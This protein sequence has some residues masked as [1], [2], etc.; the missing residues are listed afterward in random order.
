MTK[1]RI[2]LSED[3]ITNQQ[4]CLAILK[5]LGYS[6][7]VV[8]NGMEA[9]KAL[10]SVS[11]DLVLMDCQMPEMNGYETSRLV[12]DPATDIPNH[13]IPII[14]L[15]A[16][17]SDGGRE[18]CLEAG[19]ND[20]I[21]KPLNP[22]EL[23]EA[24]TRWLPTENEA[25]GSRGSDVPKRATACGERESLVF[26]ENEVL[27]R[28]DGDRELL[29]TV[30]TGFLQDMPVRLSMLRTGIQSGDPTSAT[31]EAHTIKGAAAA[32]GAETMRAAALRIE[33]AGRTGIV[34]TMAGLQ[35]EL[36]E[37]FEKFKIAWETRQN[38]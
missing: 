34:E 14:A 18:K 11:Y 7:D 38:Q 33:E 6:A 26:H 2:L 5:K 27:V 10:H 37:E 36:D 35:T 8:A 30:V 25:E 4:I 29:E 13:R 15:T 32:V 31:L 16:D 9:L 24:L 1:K 3:S 21:T 28:L 19:M 20:Y 17:I 23:A 12:R 22:K